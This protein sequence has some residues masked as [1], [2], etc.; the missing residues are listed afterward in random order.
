MI[1]TNLAHGVA[2][3]Y[4]PKLIVR[5]KFSARFDA[6]NVAEIIDFCK[7]GISARCAAR[8]FHCSK[9]TILRVINKQGVYA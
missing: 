7:P 9:G 4:R 6:K 8:E 3:P 5:N 1:Q 2:W